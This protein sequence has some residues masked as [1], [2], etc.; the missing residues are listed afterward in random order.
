MGNLA[1][2]PK[3]LRGIVL[4]LSLVLTSAVYAQSPNLV[5]PPRTIT[6]ISAF[7]SRK[8]RMPVGLRS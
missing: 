2:G 4:A 3:P 5:A 7:W 1:A 6:D 8:N